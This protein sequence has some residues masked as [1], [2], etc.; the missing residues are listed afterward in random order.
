MDIE[1][2]IFVAIHLFLQYYWDIVKAKPCLEST[3]WKDLQG[4]YP[5]LLL[6]EI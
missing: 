1:L 3:S 2:Y 4:L 6:F 5:F